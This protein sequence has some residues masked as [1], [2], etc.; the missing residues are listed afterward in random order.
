MQRAFTSIDAL[1]E[2]QAKPD[3]LAVLLVEA[4]IKTRQRFWK[5]IAA[6]RRRIAALPRKQQ[7]VDAPI[8]KLGSAVGEFARVSGS[9]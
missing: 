6:L 5:P 2:K 8:D 9:R 1:A 3:D 7:R 4:Q